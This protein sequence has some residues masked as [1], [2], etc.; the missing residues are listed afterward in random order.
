MR[1]HTQTINVVVCFGVLGAGWIT[2][3]NVLADTYG[4]FISQTRTINGSAGA[5][6]GSRP[7]SDSDS[8]VA[9]D[10]GPFNEGASASAEIL[11]IALGTGGGTQDSTILFSG[12]SASGS[13]FATA[14]SFEF[15][16]FADGSGATRFVAEFVL[17]E[18]A[19][20]SLVGEIS[21]FDS[22]LTFFSL[23]DAAIEIFG[24]SVNG[25]A[26]TLPINE[27]GILPPGTYM[28]E[29]E[30]LGTAFA[31]SFTSEF[32]FANFELDFNLE[33]GSTVPAVGT[34]GVIVMI[35][36]ILCTA[37]LVIVVPRRTARR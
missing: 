33:L 23:R 26:T 6:D 9:S 29:I 27:S 37:T 25:P 14:E 4:V 18:E 22:G 13:A 19:G 7:I 28:L 1:T 30:S 2:T 15:N 24:V 12:L 35:G 20:Y 34:G 11:D 31:D 21:A 3:D 5:D 36:L 10:F 16:G 17:T 8:D 32:A